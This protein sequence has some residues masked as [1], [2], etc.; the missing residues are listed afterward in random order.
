[1]LTQ[2]PRRTSRRIEI[3]LATAAE[4][5]SIFRLRHEIYA[6]ELAQHAV[7]NEGRLSDALDASNVYLTA[8][9]GGE[10]AG[11]VSLTPPDALRYSL[12]KYM[13]RDE[14]PFECDNG[15]F[16]VRVLTVT[17]EHRGSPIA[18]LLMYAAL[19]WVEAHGGTRI[20]AI[21][22]R[23]VLELYRKMGLTPLGREIACG[24]V[25]FELMAATPRELRDTITRRTSTFEHIARLVDWRLE[26]P[27]R[28]QAPCFHGG[29]FWDA[30]GDELDSLWRRHAVVNADVLDAWFPPSPAVCAALRKDLDW[31]LQTS[32][33]TGCEG[34]LRVI[35]RVRGVDESSLLQGDGSSRLIFHAFRSWLDSTSRVLLLDPTYGEY[36]HVLEKVI[37]C[38]VSRLELVREENF[39]LDPAR[40]VER[41]RREPF[42]LVV[43]VNPNSP[44]GQHVPRA[45]LEPAL[46]QIPSRTRVWID[47]TYVEYAGAGESLEPFAAASGNVVV[48]KSM[49]KVYALSGARAAY[50]VGPPSVIEPLRSTTPP[51]AVSLPAQLA[52]VRALGDPAYYSGRYAETHALR[53]ELSAALAG[54]LGLGIIPGVINAILCF[55]PEGSPGATAVVERAR[56][57]GV[58]LR[59]ASGFS[60]RLGSS[61]IRIAVKDRASNRKIIEAL[62]SA[63]GRPSQS[64][65]ID[66]SSGRGSPLERFAS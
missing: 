35:S 10:L 42:D 21:G 22:R 38:R 46:R 56:E 62:R 9:C 24:A 60:S 8:K 6:R 53:N 39:A 41:C 61:T 29:A 49:S 50:L 14:L 23:E 3:S 36:A 4:R 19:R 26:I 31:L 15:L 59:D 13:S 55:L 48:C 2:I 54:E 37:G 57:L 47:E 40:L 28:A 64:S 52:V 5:E 27:F 58:Y 65:S 63:M 25:R 66:E 7:N 45:S 34:M 16:E 44:T 43:L 12:E 18:L 51:W 30:I 17:P 33:P 32:P 1:M 20:V 11:F